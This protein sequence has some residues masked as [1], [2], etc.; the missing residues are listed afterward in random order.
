M[1]NT[2]NQQSI[3]EKNN[4]YL[5]G[6]K[7]VAMTS[8]A[9]I[10]LQA[11]KTVSGCDVAEDFVTQKI[12]GELN[13]QVDVG[14]DHQ[15]PAETEV[16]IYTAAHQGPE[17]PIVSQA[18]GKQIAVLSQAEALALFFNQKK[19]VA[20][21]GVGGKSTVSAMISWILT[22]L[23]MNPSFS[24][25]VGKI[26]GLDYTG[27]WQANS[28]WFVAEAD[29]YVINPKAVEN[30]QPITP[31]FS[32]L[33][34]EICVCTNLNYDHPDVYQNLE[35]TKQVFADFYQQIV[36]NGS[37]IFNAE[38][39]NMN[40]LL[41]TQKSGLEK[42]GIK[43]LTYGENKNA[44]LQLLASRVENQ[45]S[46]AEILLKSTQEKYQL[47]LRIP[48]KFNLYNAMAALLAVA[49]M[50]VSFEKAIESLA[51]FQSTMRRFEFVGEKNGV[52]YLDDYAHH[53]DEIKQTILAFDQ[54]FPKKRKV[55]AFQPHTYSRTKQLFTD[56]TEALG[57]SSEVILLDIFSSARE[58]YDPTVS[59]DL[60]AEAVKKNHPDCKIINLKTVE[61]LAD[62]CQH[63]LQ[64]GDALLTMGAGDIYKVH[65]L[66]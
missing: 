22:Q 58:K 5:M 32:F 44:D 60:L 16:V 65:R 27:R 59:S 3:L 8:L 42:R 12:L 13:L 46:H 9:Q 39:Q 14:F 26:M 49:Q 35:Q 61:S 23:N 57:S 4:F 2:Q 63:Q 25:G 50:G 43:I 40:Q 53:P 31:R 48:G 56:F 54:W 34:P 29:E 1:I 18:K 19:G 28:Q 15:L 7:G 55:I 66:V 38:C 30:N 20:V 17:N 24:V 6:I 36:D 47:K 62:Y 45:A 21:C 11:G 33:N 51:N 64:R 37:L 41:A 52:L 10:L